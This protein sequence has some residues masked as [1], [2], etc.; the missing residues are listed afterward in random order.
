MTLSTID[1]LSA[2][3]RLVDWKQGLAPKTADDLL[4]SFY[5]ELLDDFKKELLL[6]SPTDFAAI[7]SR[8]RET[9]THYKWHLG[10]SGDDDFTLWLHEYKSIDHRGPGYA[11]SVHNHR[12]AL[13]V[14]VLAGGYT[15][16]RFV[17]S[18]ADADGPGLT[19]VESVRLE[20]GDTYTIPADH[21]H[22]ISGIDDHTL[23]LVIQHR[24]TRTF[25]IS[26]DIKSR[27]TITHIPIEGRYNDLRTSL[28]QSLERSFES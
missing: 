12:Y 5:T 23:T 10:P 8:S 3:L 28:S 9:S 13:S 21:L 11:Q 16:S 7:C 27:R 14:L 22:S 6:V 15:H 24:V 18:A 4:L 20:A 25:S 1:S 26:V 17:F 2:A 19:T